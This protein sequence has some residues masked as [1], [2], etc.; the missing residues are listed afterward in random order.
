MS[1]RW[2]PKLIAFK[3]TQFATDFCSSNPPAAGLFTVQ[4]RD[5]KS[6]SAVACILCLILLSLSKK[7]KRIGASDWSDLNQVDKLAYLNLF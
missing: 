4:Q 5:T 1:G 3:R 2:A 6:V 7:Q